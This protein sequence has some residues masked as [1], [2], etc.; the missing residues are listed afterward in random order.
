MAAQGS[1][2]SRKFKTMPSA[3]KVM[4]TIF[5]DAQRILLTDYLPRGQTI[6]GSYYA[7][8]VLKLREAIKEKRRG[9]LQMQVFFHQDDAP[10]HK[11]H[12]SMTTIHN[13]GFELVDHPQYSPDLAHSDFYLF[14]KMKEDLRGKSFPDDNAVN[15]W[16]DE[17]PEEFFQ[18]GIKALEHRWTKCIE[19]QE[20]YIEK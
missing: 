15:E 9:K 17:Q 10:V 18:A 19:L 8:L 16:L 20:D 1:L 11:S 5:W 3:G 2:P 13:A 14:P 6:T 7:Q 12:I 4:A